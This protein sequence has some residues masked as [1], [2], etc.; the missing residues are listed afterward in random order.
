MKP[1]AFAILTSST[2]LNASNSVQL[3]PLGEF[4]AHDGRPGCLAEANCQTWRL[5]RERAEQIVAAHAARRRRLL[6]DYEHATLF[7]KGTGDAVP[8]AGWGTALCIKDDGLYAEPVEWTPRAAQMIADK[9]YQYSSPVFSFDANTGDVLDVQM[10]AITNDP[11]LDGMAALQVALSA[12]APEFS[13]GVDMDIKELLERLRWMFNLPTLATV[14][15]IMGEIDKLKSRLNDTQQAAASFDLLAFVDTAQND[16]AQVVALTA[17][18]A[19]LTSL[20]SSEPDPAKYVPVAVLTAAQNR[21]AELTATLAKRDTDDVIATATAEG[22]LLGEDD[23]KWAR[24]FAD[25]HGAQAL[26][27]ALSARQP[28]AALSGTQTGGKAP[29]GSQTAALSAE[30]QAAI[31]ALGQTPEQYKAA[32]SS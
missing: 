14:D 21:V 24:S 15:D 28:I 9:E 29:V 13:P 5:T 11:A 23:A 22:R 26:R 12:L 8:A 4:A 30:E 31:A 3:L 20:A 32:Q 27:D 10:C 17:N 1:I 2:E 16:A 18:V 19:R 7:K 25:T 6:I